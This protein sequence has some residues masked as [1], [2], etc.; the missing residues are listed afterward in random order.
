[1][2]FAGAGDNNASHHQYCSHAVLIAMESP[3]SLTCPV[4]VSSASLIGSH[5][6]I[7]SFFGVL[8]GLKRKKKTLAQVLEPS[9]DNTNVQL[10]LY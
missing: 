2:L 4:V 1:M 8:F 7:F 6:G 9:H 5:A 3:D 10:L